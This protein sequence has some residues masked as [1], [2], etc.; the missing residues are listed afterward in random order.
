M[1]QIIIILLVISCITVFVELIQKHLPERTAKVLLWL[2][3]AIYVIGNLYFTLG[4]RV[5]GSGTVVDL[6][7]FGTYLRK[8]EAV[9]ADFTN[10]VGFAALFLQGSTSYTSLVLNILLY[11][12]LGFLLK[13]LFPRLKGWQIVLIGFMA[14]AATELT[15]YLFKMGWLEL[16]DMI[17]NTLGTTI[18]LCCRLLQNKLAFK[19]K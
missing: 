2:A 13:V 14:S 12:P 9:K 10:A 6:R 11:Y 15:Q 16:D 18:G 3:F 8:S 7:P 4:S 17:T 5:V 19:R 1:T